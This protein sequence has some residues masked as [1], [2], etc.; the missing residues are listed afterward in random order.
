MGQGVS[1]INGDGRCA[2]LRLCTLVMALLVMG[3]WPPAAE[4][5][6]NYDPQVLATGKSLY[7]AHCAA[8]HGVNAESTVADWH[9][10]D[11]DGRYPPPPLNGTAHTWHHPLPSLMQTVREGT[12]SIGGSMPGWKETLDD[13]QIF[14]ILVWLTSL[15]PDEIYQAWR[16]A[17]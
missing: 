6:R 3:S 16:E 11:A 15:W 13:E 17:H 12:A 7:Q 2:T 1:L 5:Q 8:C 10:P 14:S 4:A 9:V